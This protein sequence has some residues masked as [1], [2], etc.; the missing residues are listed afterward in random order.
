MIFQE[1]FERLVNSEKPSKDEYAVAKW[2][3]SNVPSKKTKFDR[4][5]TVEYFTGTR[6]VDALLER[7]PWKNTLFESRQ[8]VVNFLETMLRHKFFHRAKKIVITEDELH[9]IKNLKKK[10]NNKVVNDLKEKS[11]VRTNDKTSDSLVDCKEQKYYLE[12]DH[13]EIKKVLKKKSKVKY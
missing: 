11:Q 5:H 1:G 3:R 6:V 10:I 4:I 2:I 8:E 12:E 13:E 9:R 7:S